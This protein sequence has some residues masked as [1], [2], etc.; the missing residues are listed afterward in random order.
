MARKMNDETKKW[1]TF[2]HPPEEKESLLRQVAKAEE[3][4]LYDYTLD[5]PSAS[6]EIENGI[7]KGSIKKQA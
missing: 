3:Q 6:Y 4:G 1:L 7:I 2:N 5:V